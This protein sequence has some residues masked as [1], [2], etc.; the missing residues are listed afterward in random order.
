MSIT[1]DTDNLITSPDN[2]PTFTSSSSP[3]SYNYVMNKDEES[4]R[5]AGY[6]GQQTFV[7]PNLSEHAPILADGERTPGCETV[8]VV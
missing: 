5:N 2:S 1:S 8:S 6:R 7:Y 3:P 4:S